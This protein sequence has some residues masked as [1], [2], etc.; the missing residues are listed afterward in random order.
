MYQ[1]NLK[2]LILAMEVGDSLR[3]KRGYKEQTLRNYASILG[4]DHSRS[5]SIRR[6]GNATFT[7]TRNA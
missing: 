1:T 7:I 3:P 6:E 4:R 2:T 5:Y